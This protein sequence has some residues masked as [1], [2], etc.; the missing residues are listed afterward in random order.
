MLEWDECHRQAAKVEVEEC[1]EL[2]R[3]SFCVPVG[4]RRTDGRG[5]WQDDQPSLSFVAAAPTNRNESPQCLHQ[6]DP[7]YWWLSST[8]C[9]QMLPPRPETRPLTTLQALPWPSDWC[10]VARMRPVRPRKSGRTGVLADAQSQQSGPIVR[11]LEFDVHDMTSGR[12][13]LAAQSRIQG[14]Q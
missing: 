3:E 13:T 1:A 10:V 12:A 5:Q 4:R 8:S 7:C 14:G 11:R 6:G 2:S 9:W